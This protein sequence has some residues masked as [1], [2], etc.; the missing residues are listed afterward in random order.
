M[1][2]LI[3]EEESVT[4]AKVPLLGDLPVLGYVFKNKSR[5]K[6]RRNLFVFV[7]PHI[8]R[9]RGVSFDDLHKQSWIAKMK[10]DELIEP[11]TSTTRSSRP[12]RA[13]R[14]RRRRTSRDARHQLAGR[15][16]PLRRGSGRAGSDRAEQAA[17][18]R[19]QVA[20]PTAPQDPKTRHSGDDIPA[21]R[22]PLGFRAAVLEF[23]PHETG[24]EMRPRT[25][26]TGR[27]PPCGSA[28]SR[29][30]PDRKQ[31]SMRDL[32]RQFVKEHGLLDEDRLEEA[33]R[34]EEETGQSFEKIILHKGY[35]SEN[36]LLRTLAF[37]LELPYL[38]G[39]AEQVVPDDFRQQR[40]GRLRAQLRA[41]SGR[42]RQRR[43][44]HRDRV[45]ARHAPDGRPRDDAASARSSPCS[46]RAPRSRA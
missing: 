39:L 15:R 17:R 3:S 4:E 25:R 16:R 44:A 20:R 9:Q 37:A 27:E 43:H 2:G 34:L 23:A 12:T 30:A 7:T 46:R 40:A 35:M 24:S 19:G 28:P 32:I 14:A 21:A 22:A 5:R 10:A 1:G 26:S 41:R 18:A 42:P 33:F 36:D 29:R 11:S 45:P 31:A 38:P 6:I 8:L 13:S